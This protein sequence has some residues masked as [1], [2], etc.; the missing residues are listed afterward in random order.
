MSFSRE[1]C[2]DDK[3]AGLLERGTTMA[4]K[5]NA[6]LGL[7]GRHWR[8]RTLATADWEEEEF[9]LDPNETGF[10]ALHLWNVGDVDGPAVPEFFS[11]DMGKPG[12]PGG[13]GTDSRSIHPAGDRCGARR[14]HGD[15]PR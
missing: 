13:V 6:A 1:D 7:R 12:D 3:A 10:V 15:L 11:V 14:G 8:T 5:M 2:K 9:A 4:T